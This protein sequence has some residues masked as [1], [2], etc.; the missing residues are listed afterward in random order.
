MQAIAT[1]MVLVV[2]GLHLG[3]MVLEMFLWQEPWVMD[4]FGM[5]PSQAAAS[6][7][8]A[9][10]QGLYNGL[11]AAG[12]LWSAFASDGLRLRVFFLICVVMAGVFGAL[13]AK[14]SILYVQ[15]APAALALLVVWSARRS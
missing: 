5:S 3:F 9:A 14:T 2:A 6:A 11:L 4:R 12:L 8:L 15:A 1:L 13:S 10:N 7:T